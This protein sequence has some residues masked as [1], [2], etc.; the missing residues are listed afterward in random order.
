V[1]PDLAALTG[2]S[3]TLLTMNKVGPRDGKMWDEATARMTGGFRDDLAS[4]LAS[5]S[6]ILRRKVDTF[7]TSLDFYVAPNCPLGTRIARK[8]NLGDFE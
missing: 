1:Q 4:A 2:R 3:Q 6:P 7:P 5:R 8:G